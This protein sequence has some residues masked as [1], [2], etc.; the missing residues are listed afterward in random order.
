MIRTSHSVGEANGGLAGAHA[1]KGYAGGV[2]MLELQT[3][4]T[5]SW[6][7]YNDSANKPT[8]GR[9]MRQ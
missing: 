8:V 6:Q 7:A 3:L 5:A 2:F 9:R 1:Y 4:P